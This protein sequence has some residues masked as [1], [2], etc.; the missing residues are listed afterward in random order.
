MRTA[1]VS[2][3]FAMSM[4]WRTTNMAIKLKIWAMLYIGLGLAI[5]HT[6]VQVTAIG[7]HF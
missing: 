6:V 3:A 2:H 7:G 1:T 5:L 4:I